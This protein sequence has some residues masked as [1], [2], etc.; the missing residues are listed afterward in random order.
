MRAI[1]SGTEIIGRPIELMNRR[2][3]GTSRP[4]FQLVFGV[5]QDGMH[6]AAL[7]ATG[8]SPPMPV[9]TLKINF[10]KPIQITIPGTTKSILPFRISDNSGLAWMVGVLYE[11]VFQTL[12]SSNVRGSIDPFQIWEFLFRRTQGYTGELH[13]TRTQLNE[14][15]EV[16]NQYRRTK[17]PQLILTALA[18]F[19]TER[20]PGYHAGYVPG[21]GGAGA[22]APGP[23]GY[24]TW[25]APPQPVGAGAYGMA[26]APYQ[27]MSFAPPRAPGYAPGGLAPSIALRP[28]DGPGGIQY[29]IPL[30]A[31]KT[32][33]D[34]LKLF[35][36]LMV[37]QSSPAAT[38]AVTLST[39]V[40]AD[41]T[42]QTNVC[43][44]P[45]WVG[46]STTDTNLSRIYPWATLQFLSITDWTKLSKEARVADSILKPEWREFI[47]ELER[48]YASAGMKLTRATPTSYFLDQLRVTDVDKL[49][50]CAEGRAGSVPFTPIQGALD[51]IQ[52]AYTAHVAAVWG[53]LN[54]LIV[55]I[56]DPAKRTE[57]VRLHPDVFGGTVKSSK[58]YVDEKAT[59]ARKLIADFYLN[60]ERIYVETI[61]AL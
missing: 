58:V 57:V 50:V 10:I 26:P 33:V 53:I 44:D 31:T 61:K 8:G 15:N 35:R 5:T 37:R 17:N 22:Y 3:T 45:Y 6:P 30:G 13:D 28:A 29:D 46:T 21:P 9:G 60:I 4:T 24:P 56:A 27:P 49:K 11:D 34:T 36:D 1:P 38:R 42:I 47:N 23:Y 54:S 59:Q 48:L 25:G 43:R 7:S 12:A 16:F 41:R 19:L 2:A 52:A 39:K 32:I 40:N 51:K 18:R 14:A 20:V 55:V